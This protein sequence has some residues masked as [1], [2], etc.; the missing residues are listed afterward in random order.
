MEELKALLAACE[1]ASP[2]AFWIGGALALA[3]IF[4]PWRRRTKSM[5]LDFAFWQSRLSLKSRQL[6]VMPSLLVVVTLL[7]ALALSTPCLA[8]ITRVPL[9]GKPVMAIVDVSGSM[10]IEPGKYSK[11][12][13][14]PADAR[15]NF[16][17][18]HAVFDDLIGRWPDV[19]FGLVIYSTE[20]Y[21][22]RYFA[23][24]NELLQDTM[25]NRAEIDFISSGT[26]PVEAMVRARQFLMSHVKGKD[27]AIVLISD[28]DVDFMTLLAIGEE[29]QKDQLAGIKLYVLFIGEILPAE[30]PGG[31]PAIPAGLR[32][33]SMYDKAGIDEM[34]LELSRMQS[35]PMEEE[36]SLAK[37]SLIPHLVWPAL[38]LMIVCLVLSETALRRIP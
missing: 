1:F 18:A 12:A 24:K 28:L 32:I 29:A 7:L 36:E 35:S 14:K 33:V 10:G 22:A 8:T 31:S 9:S 19:D 23:Y 2:L 6:W 25:D 13:E 26:R 34:C 21:I 38:G 5:P 11:Q 15:T 4:I 27:K 3:A 17:K 30:N 37:A 16:E 20:N